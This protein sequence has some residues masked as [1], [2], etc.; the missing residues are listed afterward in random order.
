MSFPEFLRQV[1][2]RLQLHAAPPP[3]D[4]RNLEFA[5]KTGQTISLSLLLDDATVSVG[6][7]LCFYPEQA[8]QRGLFEVLLAANAFGYG[9]GGAT[10]AVDPGASKIFLFRNFPLD[11][12]DIEAFAVALRQF[13]DTHRRWKEAYESGKLPAF[14]SAD[15]VPATA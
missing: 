1:I 3:D 7:L 2:A 12:M 11:G 6:A 8:R 4:A 9:T 5:L 13:V 10:F 14:A 15:A